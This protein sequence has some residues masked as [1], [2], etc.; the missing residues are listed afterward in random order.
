MQQKQGIS[1]FG[2]FG[3][4]IGLLGVGIIL[5]AISQ[6]IILSSVTDLSTLL[7]GDTKALMNTILQPE[8][9]NKARW[10]QMIGTFFMMFLPT[11][12][13]ARVCSKKPFEFLGFG[14]KPGLAQVVMVVAIAVTG[15]FLSGA[16]GELN[17]LIPISQSMEKYFKGMENEYS[18]QVLAMAT[19]KSFGEYVFTLVL[20]AILPAIFE[21]M[22]F[23]AGLQNILIKWTNNYWIGIIVTSLI[24]SAIHLSYY[25]F[26]PRFGLGIILG[27]IFYYSKSIWLSIAAHFLNNAVAIT[28]MYIA[29]KNNKPMQDVMDEGFPL[30]IGAVA[31]VFIVILFKE[32]KKRSEGVVLQ[33]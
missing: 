20:I 21:E 16:L 27:L 28:A 17:K 9:V 24:F 8:H 6:L 18:Q 29:T 25:G 12:L 22:L 30:W 26:L 2:Q 32:F 10:M 4:L 3:I 14:Q 1:Y 31:L 7:K 19:M 5:A 23:R 15:L 13:Y 33:P 11:F